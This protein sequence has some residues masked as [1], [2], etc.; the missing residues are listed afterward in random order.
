MTEFLLTLFPIFIFVILLLVHER[1]GYWGELRKAYSAKLEEDEKKKLRLVTIFIELK[2]KSYTYYTSI[3]KAF[4]TERY[5]IIDYIFPLNLILS[6]LKIN[7]DDIVSFTYVRK[8]GRKYA[9]LLFGRAKGGYILVPQKTMKGENR[10][11]NNAGKLSRNPLK[12]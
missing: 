3:N 1:V 4:M 6:S 2:E 11:T 5:L 7:M 9:K 12:R 8:W 10:D